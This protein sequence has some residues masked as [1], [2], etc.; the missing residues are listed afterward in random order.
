MSC[1]AL[2]PVALVDGDGE[3]TFR[4]GVMAGAD[5]VP[6]VDDGDLVLGDP[7]PLQHLLVVPQAAHVAQLA[8]PSGVVLALGQE[9]TPEP[10]PRPR[11]HFVRKIERITYRPQE[12]WRERP[13]FPELD[14]FMDEQ[15]ELGRDPHQTIA[16]E[17]T[18]APPDVAARLGL[19]S[20][21]TVVVRR[22]VRYL[23]GVPFNTND[24]YY[25]LDLV[26]GSEIMLPPDI[27]RG[28]NQVLAELGAEQTHAVDEIE[29]R[30]P[31][32]DEA[33]RL[34]IG[35]GV[36][37]AMHR[38]TGYTADGRPVRVVRNVLPG[39]RHLIVFERSRGRDSTTPS[40]NAHP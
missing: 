34:E 26:E 33:E 16:V 31:S 23:D 2:L 40:S 3:F 10:E 18:A 12:E 22:R 8:E 11:G 37:V 17:L 1:R 38:A 25:P 24:S 15:V 32:P 36:P 13:D 28:A 20:I 4:V 7:E 5:V 30:M 14:Q 6:V 29:I 9:V 35:L 21:G 19:D 27:G 39:D